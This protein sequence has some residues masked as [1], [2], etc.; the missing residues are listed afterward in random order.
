MEK[1]TV[2]DVNKKVDKMIVNTVSKIMVD[3]PE[4]FEKLKNEPPSPKDIEKIPNES[5]SLKDTKKN[6]CEEKIFLYRLIYVWA[7]ILT[8]ITTFY[9]SFMKMVE[10]FLMII[11]MLVIKFKYMIHVVFEFKTK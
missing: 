9:R 8:I 10:F 1:I 2:K 3:L 5:P 6:K 7:F 11:E 4:D